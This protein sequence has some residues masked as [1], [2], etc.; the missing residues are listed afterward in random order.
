MIRKLLINCVAVFLFAFSYAQTVTFQTDDG[1]TAKTICKGTDI[2][3]NLSIDPPRPSGGTSTYNVQ[4]EKTVNPTF[5]RNCQFP[6][7]DDSCS[8][9][10]E[11]PLETTT[12]TV[13]VNG[14]P[15]GSVRSTV[16][17]TVEEVP[18]P[19]LNTT[20]F[21]CGR[22]GMINLFD[23]LDGGPQPGGVWSNGTGTYDTADP[24][25]GA[26]TYTI[27]NGG[28]CP[29]V[30]AIITVRSCG[31]N[32]A[33]DDGVPD[34]TDN[35]D[36]NDGI[37]D[38]IE[39][40]F[41]TAATTSPIFILEEDFGFG[42]PTRSRYAEGL[43]LTYNPVLPQDIN[44]N[45]G[46]Y[47]VATSTHYRT[48][49]GFDATFLATDRIG[50]VDADGNTD[51]RYLAINMKSSAFADKPVFVAENLPV[52]P[53]IEY[54]FTMSIAGLN[55]NTDEIKASLT[56][57]VVDQATG[58]P[59]FSED[60]GEISNGTDEWILVQS[61]FVPDATV[62]VVTI[63]VIN[64][65]GTDGDGNDIG[66]DNIF[67][68]TNACDFDR[69]GIPNSQD[70]DAD[71]DGIYDIVESGNAAADGNGDGRFDGPID[72]DGTSTTVVHNVINSDA[73]ANLD[74]LDID[75]D[76]DGIIDNI[77]GQSTA[78]YISP[79]G[80]DGDF[81][82]VDDSYDTNG[83]AIAPVN[84][85]TNTAPDYIDNNSD[86]VSGD[87][88]EDTIEAYDTDQDGI[89][90][91]LAGGSDVDGDGL[92]DAFDTVVLDRLTGATNAN[93]GG[94]VP[95]DFPNNHNPLTVE[96]DWREEIGDV[97]LDPLAIMV[98]DPVDLFDELPEGTLTTGSW[99][100]PATG[101]ALTGGHL[102]TLDPTATGVLDGE[103]IYTLPV[104]T[105][106]CP[107]IRYLIDVTIDDTCQCPDIDEPIVPATP[108]TTCIDAAPL[109][110]VTVTL[111][112]GLEGRWYLADGVTPIA[113]AQ[114]TDTFTPIRAELVLGDN[115]FR[116]EAYEPVGMCASD[117]V[118]VI[119][120]V[121]APPEAGEPNDTPPVPVTLC[122]GNTAIINL[123]DELTGEDTGGVW[124]DPTATV[125]P[126]GTITASTN[127]EGDYSY[128]VSSN[129]CTDT[130]II[131]VEISTVPT[132]AFGETTC[133]ADRATYNAS[134]ITN[135]SWNISIDP[136]DA[137]TV[138]VVNSM[139]TAI[140][141]GVDITITATNPDNTSCVAMLMITAP[142]CS[143]PDVAEPTNPSNESICV[144]STAPVLSVNV[145]PGQ[146]ANWYDQDGNSLR[147]DSATFT[148]TDTDIGDYVYRVEAF[149]TT[150]NCASGRIE[151]FYQILDVPI[152][153]PIDAISAC[154]SYE[155][156]ELELGNYFTEMNGV[157]TQLNPGEIINTSQVVYVYAETGTTPNCFDE[158][159]LD[160]TINQLP[161]PV[162]P[163]NP[164]D[165]F[166][167]RYTLPALQNGQQY[168]TGPDGAGTQL[169][170]GDIILESQTIF[171]R[172]V[173]GIGC[174]NEVSFFVEI[175]NVEELEIEPGII[176]VGPNT[177]TSFLINTELSDIDFSFDWSFE[178]TIIPGATQSTYEAT[179]AGTYTVTYTDVVSTCEGSSQI[180]ITGVNA[181]QSLDLQLSSGSFADNSD[182]IATVT[183]DSTYQYILDNG[184]PQD[185]N[186]FTNVP[187]GLHEVTAIDTN[188]CGSVTASI[189]VVG[190]P[191][192]FT[193]NND[194][195]NDQW[196]VVG[197][198]D[199][200]EMDI[201]IFDRYGK[202]LQQLNR[203][204]QWDGTY[205][206]KPLPA[207]D[208]WF[209][210]EFKDGSATYRRHFT[211]KR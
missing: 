177:A 91:L 135:G 53:G 17:V 152:I 51:G 110:S 207:T 61:S 174:E 154:E 14:G 118:D 75:A 124:T 88:L 29:P 89:P 43:G 175:T 5:I 204:N 15:S 199:T 38:V 109:P 9:Y 165:R 200:P 58:T 72:V 63:R 68:S 144:G 138:D 59:L 41:C 149:D 197:N 111:T 103:Y 181:P 146:T 24:N 47:N 191:A 153:D 83:T 163:V 170:V 120:T 13:T 123:Y 159:P 3:L 131:T 94:T 19:G 1:L 101:T 151:V 4:W 78:G 162:A 183:G 102:G 93:N 22:S 193:P 62:N 85:N 161:N 33:D 7:P 69:D 114:N 176:C 108:I 143:C 87:C 60:S 34:V 96:R 55:N 205:G 49:V 196:G 44:G 116:V 32:D 113:R 180:T 128:T 27:D 21:L 80:I 203:D 74:F 211:L 195:F 140:T 192:F 71:N 202:L 104:L 81:N 132:L 136:V 26:F 28:A 11:T 164:G 201:F 129:G 185:S 139:I 25:G 142:D 122:E 92:D 82:G 70:L 52:L 194:G 107:P 119:I 134:F 106:G 150:E 167:E 67:L 178:G 158:K 171:L 99:S 65:Q 73:D 100:V 137:G 20:M 66:I 39:D 208:Y 56:I 117:L 188:R 166:C 40:G 90:D 105:A 2:Q 77:E 37:P 190:F 31:D 145:L 16:T 173:D 10:R 48:N 97:D 187:L 155:L 64:R 54:D 76:G 57:E 127:I 209:V 36:D 186:I 160:I 172:E 18:N 156:P 84:S 42:G 8:F 157:G 50:D 210:A 198:V 45:D 112:S 115:L 126:D 184:S 182:I 147:M 95:T 86:P 169:N 6:S 30:S 130:A 98:C 46:E 206:G 148:P 79:S 179:Q 125:I 168:F 35:D 133:A 141:D 12:Y 23:E 121:T 189:F